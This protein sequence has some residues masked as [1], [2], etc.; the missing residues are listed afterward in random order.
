M[1]YSYEKKLMKCDR[2]DGTIISRLA[3]D[4]FGEI[5]LLHGK[6]N[7]LNAWCHLSLLLSFVLIYAITV[8]C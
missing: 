3:Y 4:H 6:T 7:T 2:L 1:F 5:R 8:S